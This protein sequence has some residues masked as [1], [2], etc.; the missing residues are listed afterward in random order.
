MR[1]QVKKKSKFSLEFVDVE[2]SEE[3]PSHYPIKKTY[4]L[5]ILEETLKSSDE[6]KEEDLEKED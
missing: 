2:E 4:S 3:E 5:D 6:V 1:S